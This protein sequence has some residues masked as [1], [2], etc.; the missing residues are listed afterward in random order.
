ML[1]NHLLT[2]VLLIFVMI[3]FLTSGSSFGQSESENIIPPDEG[4]AQEAITLEQEITPEDQG[5]KQGGETMSL[6]QLIR[7]G[8]IVGYLI[9][10][11]SIVALGLVIDY[12]I[13][14][15]RS[16]ITPP[17]D[18]AVLKKLIQMINVVG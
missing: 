2:S 9:I 1:Q 11:L 5:E 12:A 18:I 3:F 6:L 4:I 8:G 7:K 16:K 17:K 13:T 15:R 10:L 14:I